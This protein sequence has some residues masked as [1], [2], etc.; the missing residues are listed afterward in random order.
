MFSATTR[1]FFFPEFFH[2]LPCFLIPPWGS[3]TVC[4]PS[5]LHVLLTNQRI[6]RG[7]L[8]IGKMNASESAKGVYHPIDEDLT[9]ICRLSHVH[10]GSRRRPAPDRRT[11]FSRP[12]YLI[13]H[14]RI[15][16]GLFASIKKLKPIWG[17]YFNLT[18]LHLLLQQQAHEYRL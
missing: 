15:K 5:A 16:T 12:D 4:N 8:T 2:V 7:A 18:R 6:L 17:Q 13:C 14:P 10:L 9:R 11:V 3:Y 1:N